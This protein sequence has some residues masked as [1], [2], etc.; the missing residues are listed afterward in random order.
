MVRFGFPPLALLCY[1]ADYLN[2]HLME[3]QRS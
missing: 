1:L 2:G 3:S